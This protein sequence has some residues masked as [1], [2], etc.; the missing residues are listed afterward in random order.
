M[1]KEVGA[2]GRLDI[3]LDSAMQVQEVLDFGLTSFKCGC[4]L[5][6]TATGNNSKSFDCFTQQT[7]ARG[8]TGIGGAKGDLGE[9]TSSKTSIRV[10]NQSAP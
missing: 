4:N 8:S 3:F 2:G 7:L 10:C 9:G 5:L 1:S 6:L